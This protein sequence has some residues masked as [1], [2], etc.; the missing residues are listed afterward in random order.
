MTALRRAT[1]YRIFGR[2][3]RV[4]FSGR[5]GS[6]ILE[7]EL[8]LYPRAGADGAPDLTVVHAPL[9]EVTGYAANPGIHREAADGFTMTHTAV[10]VR[11]VLDGSA[12]QRVCFDERAAPAR[13]QRSAR[14]WLDA[15]HTARGERAG[16]HFHESALIPAL[17][18]D[19]ERILVHASALQTPSGEVTLFG[20]TG[21]VGK[22]SLELELGLNHGHRF[23]ADDISVVDLSGTV[24][25]NLA[26]PKIYGYNLTGDDALAERVLGKRGALDR[27][28]WRAHLARGADKV[29]RRVSPEHLY[30]TYSREGGP[31]G[32]YVILARE[33][34]AALTA[35]PLDPAR[36]AAMSVDVMATEY[37]AFHNHLR[38][39]A[40]NR[41]LRGD[42]PA[43]RIED[44]LARWR[45]D[46]ADV[47]RGVPCELVRIPTDL[48]HAAY[49]REMAALMA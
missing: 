1:T 40:Y 10:A 31:L 3:V 17:H 11:F 28:H 26:Y 20:G 32:R 47:L 13:W 9:P 4:E 6:R 48:P 2:T 34:R 39:H 45:R 37:Y 29:R 7:G 43:I 33:T 25:P 16:V 22:T 41:S 44:V 14:R 38:W 8:A 42:S 18:F 35:E 27:L 12:V 15:Q 23:V 49:K 30:G 21:G 36:A 24:H 19:P 46:L 5:P